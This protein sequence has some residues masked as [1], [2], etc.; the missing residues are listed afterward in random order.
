MLDESVIGLEMEE[1]FH[2]NWRDIILY[3]LSVGAQPDELE[4]VYEKG[5]KA[6]PTFG[7][8]PCVATFGTEPYHEEMRMPTSQIKGLRTDGTVHMDHKLVIHKPLPLNGVLNVKKIISGIYD[9]GEGKGAK[10]NV[11]IIACDAG[12][13]LVCSNTMGYLNRWH[14]GFGGPPTPS[15]D[16][17][18][19]E[20]EPDHTAS[21]CFPL[22]APLM[23]RLT[24]D[25]YAIHVDPDTAAKAGFPGP[26][27][28]GLCS[29]GYACRMLINSLRPGR[30]EEIKSLENQ[31]RAIAFPGDR[32]TLQMWNVAPDETLFR[33][34]RDSDSKV[35]LDRGRVVWNS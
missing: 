33:M 2:Y 30:P 5:L 20:R 31:F 28:H 9:R 21:N 19:P 34:V 12:G 18:I 1:K 11:E 29:L 7:V 23:Y 22:N 25:T 6:L 26:I 27:I 3:N 17:K 13:D 15:N 32:F 14:G 24:G 16:I 8:I 35:I 4:Y 10:I